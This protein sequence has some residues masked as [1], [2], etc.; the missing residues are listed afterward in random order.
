MVSLRADGVTARRPGSIRD[1]FAAIAPRYDLLNTVLSFGQHRRWRRFATSRW[2]APPNAIALDLATGTGDF[3]AAAAGRAR[4]VVGIDFCLPM[5][6]L[7][8]RK[9]RGRPVTLMAADALSIPFADAAFDL[10]TI[11][12]GQR[13]VADTG[14][15]YREIARVLK[16]GGVLLALEFARPRRGIVGRAAW[17]YVRHLTPVIGGIVNAGA[18]RYL[19]QSINDFAPPQETARALAAAGFAPVTTRDFVGGVVVLFDA[20][21]GDCRGNR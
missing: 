7:A 14:R 20:R 1:M 3:A 18:Y 19:V 8:A 11:A 16:P 9:L 17:W 4:R 12:F 21:K 6:D 10:A 13:N 5:L 2:Q 15:L